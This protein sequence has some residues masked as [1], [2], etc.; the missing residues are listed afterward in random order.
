MPYD[1]CA[2]HQVSRGTGSPGRRMRRQQLGLVV[3][4][5]QQQVAAALSR[6]N[7]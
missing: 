1:L 7:A 4:V 6:S 2:I 5:V 3:A